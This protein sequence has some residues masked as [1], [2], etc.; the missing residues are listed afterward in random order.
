MTKQLDQ[1]QLM[2]IAKELVSKPAEKMPD[3]L[4]KQEEE[5]VKELVKTLRATNLAMKTYVQQMSYN[6]ALRKQIQI[7]SSVKK[8]LEQTIRAEADYSSKWNLLMQVSKRIKAT[9][10]ALSA[11]DQAAVKHLNRVID[12]QQRKLVRLFAKNGIYPSSDLIKRGKEARMA[13]QI[14][15]FLARSFSTS[16]EAAIYGDGLSSAAKTL[17]ELEAKL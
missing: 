16:A 13:G 6:D 15:S 2:D 10:A 14:H 8:R 17:K 4:T 5:T 1:Q 12:K 9:Q 3:Y 11:S 7:E